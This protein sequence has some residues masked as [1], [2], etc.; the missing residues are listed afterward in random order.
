VRLAGHQFL[1]VIPV[2]DGEI[3][4]PAVEP[5]LQPDHRL[6]GALV[7]DPPEGLLDVHRN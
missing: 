3:L 4:V 2:G 5:I 6:D 7:I 1:L